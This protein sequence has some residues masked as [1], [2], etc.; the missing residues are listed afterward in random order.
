MCIERIPPNLNVV[1][2]GSFT[3]D[4]DEGPDIESEYDVDDI[5]FDGEYNAL[6]E[7]FDI[8]H[9]YLW[10][11]NEQEFDQQEI[12]RLEEQELINQCMEEMS[13]MQLLE[14]IEQFEAEHKE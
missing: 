7:S 11:E 1:N 4:V 12:Q 8:F 9:D 5:Y 3:T 13:E 10:M 6:D 2:S 14:E